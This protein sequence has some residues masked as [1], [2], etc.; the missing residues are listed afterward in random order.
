MA[1]RVKVYEPR[2]VKDPSTD[3]PFIFDIGQNNWCLVGGVLGSWTDGT[4]FVKDDYDRLFHVRSR[5]RILTPSTDEMNKHEVRHESHITA[6]E[7]YVKHHKTSSI[8]SDSPLNNVFSDTIRIDHDPVWIFVEQQYMDGKNLIDEF[9][10]QVASK[11]LINDEEQHV[12]GKNFIDKDDQQ[13]SSKNLEVPLEG[14]ELFQ[15]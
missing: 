12:A 1:S 9:E 6:V 4:P 8:G 3:I 7:Q 10:Q 13:V 5:I 15:F 2:Y 14:E 11:N